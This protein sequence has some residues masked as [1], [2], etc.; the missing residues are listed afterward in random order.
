[1]SDGWLDR[2]ARSQGGDP[3]SD[4]EVGVL[5]DVARDVAHR[6]ERKATPI[7]TFL[8]GMSVQRQLGA[9]S[10]RGDALR[11]ATA[12]LE[13]LLPPEASS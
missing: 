9:G 12:E 4:A 1:M 2:L 3:L 6:V 11:A 13:A 5:L 8:L 7:A 10:S